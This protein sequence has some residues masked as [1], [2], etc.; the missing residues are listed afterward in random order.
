MAKGSR[1][2]EESS[3]WRIENN[4]IFIHAPVI[5]VWSR[6]GLV[7]SVVIA[8]LG[9]AMAVLAMFHPEWFHFTNPRA[10]GM[11]APG[12]LVLA[13]GQMLLTIKSVMGCLAVVRK[14][15][16]NVRGRK[17]PWRLITDV[18]MERPR[19][20]AADK[21]SLVLHIN[22]KNKARQLIMVPGGM[23]EQN[24]L[25]PLYHRISQVLKQAKA[26]LA[27]NT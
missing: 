20:G 22:K 14:D 12:I 21:P 10:A 8:M 27:G 3:F 19:T 25:A 26:K 4:Q 17:Y 2:P 7:S 9:G 23:V 5:S 15:C 16:V 18:T 13:V 1:A 11:F 6:V 24:D